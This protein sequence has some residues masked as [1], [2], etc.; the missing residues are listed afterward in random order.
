MLV[1]SYEDLCL[2][3]QSIKSTDWTYCGEGKRAE[4]IIEKC[5]REA[6]KVKSST[7]YAEEA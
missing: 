4:R 3:I 7:A 6:Q 5:M 1:F 2:I